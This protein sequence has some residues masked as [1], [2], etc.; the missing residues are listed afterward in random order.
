LYISFCFSS[1]CDAWKLEVSNYF[2]SCLAL[3]L[4]DE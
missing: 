3:R 1:T 2:K 4:A